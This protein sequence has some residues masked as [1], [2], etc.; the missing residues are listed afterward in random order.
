MGSSLLSN[1][2]RGFRNAVTASVA[3]AML[4]GLSGSAAA[5]TPKPTRDAVVATAECMVATPSAACQSAV[6]RTGDLLVDYLLWDAPPLFKDLLLNY[7]VPDT[8][9]DPCSAQNRY[10][11]IVGLHRCAPAAC[12]AHPVTCA[13]LLSR[14]QAGPGP[15]CRA[16]ILR[17]SAGGLS[18]E[19]IVANRRLSGCVSEERRGTM[20]R[21]AAYPG[22]DEPPPA[23]AM[24]GF[25][26]AYAESLLWHGE[27]YARA[28]IATVY[29][30]RLKVSED[31][32]LVLNGDSLRASSFRGQGESWVGRLQA[33]LVGPEGTQCHVETGQS[34][35]RTIML[36]PDVALHL[37]AD[38][39]T[40]SAFYA[41]FAT[42]GLAGR[43][44]VVVETPAGTVTL[45]EA[46]ANR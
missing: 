24:W 35:P 26:G 37:N 30:I 19:P 6:P 7:V 10:I 2:R 3:A 12:A 45:A 39:R 34:A 4:L 44:A 22:G 20:E 38:P 29:E 17:V 41:P 32:R 1:G 16:S 43:A 23:V 33:C 21:A 11:Q 25:H 8:I 36:A 46:V 13:E 5:F 42:M 28:D 18:G 27:P 9:A 31:H 40:A 15:A 14:P